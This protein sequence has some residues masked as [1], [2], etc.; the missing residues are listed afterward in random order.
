MSIR[1]WGEKIK[2]LT[3]SLK[4]RFSGEGATSRYYTT[5]IVILVGLSSFGLGRLS[6]QDERKEPIIIEE[7]NGVTENFPAPDINV[8][9][10][11][12][13]ATA[14]KSISGQL[15]RGGKIVASKNSTKY[16]FPWCS[17]ALRITESNKI[18]FDSEEDARAKGY[19]P[20]TNCKG[21]K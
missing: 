9:V 19:Q 4:D 12:Q 3:A 18:W 15:T 8:V 6:I 14:E 16:H 10:K 1:D 21:L 20:A 13:T 5:I 17:G 2:L 11:S 7:N